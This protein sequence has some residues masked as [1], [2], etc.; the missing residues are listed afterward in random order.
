VLIVG[1]T[2]HVNQRCKFEAFMAS[3][4]RSESV[5]AVRSCGAVTKK[6]PLTLE[7]IEQ[8]VASVQAA[9]VRRICIRPAE[10]KEAA[11]PC[12]HAA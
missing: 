2:P 6:D 9:A 11:Q 7:S 4:L 1:V 12:G 10:K 3:Q 5:K 8:A